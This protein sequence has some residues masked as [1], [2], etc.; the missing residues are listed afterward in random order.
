MHYDKGDRLVLMKEEVFEP[1][2]ESVTYDSNGLDR[3]HS[4][5]SSIRWFA[6]LKSIRG[7]L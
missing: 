3:N 5:S 2:V 1:S 4:K 7:K 6:V